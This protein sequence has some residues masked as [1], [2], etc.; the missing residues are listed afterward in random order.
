MNRKI[1]SEARADALLFA[2][3]CILF[4]I[5]GWY[6]L[7]TLDAASLGRVPGIALDRCVLGTG[8]L[9][10]LL[11]KFLC[12]RNVELS[13]TCVVLLGAICGLMF[14][15]RSLG[16][17][18]VD[19]QNIQW[20]LRGDWAEHYASWESYRAGSWTWPLG[21]IPDLFY[22]VGTTIVFTDSTPLLAIPAKLVR[23]L[24]PHPFQYIGIA[25]A[26]NLILQGVFAALLMKRL[27]ASAAGILAG[28]LLFLFAPILIWRIGHD[29]LTAHWLIL[30][31]LLLYFRR[32]VA[33]LPR[34]I[35][36][37]C[38][39]AFLGALIHPYFPP[40]VMAVALAYW[41]RRVWVD[42]ARTP[43]AAAIALCAI[44]LPVMFAWWIAGAFTLHIGDGGGGVPYGIYSFN[45]LGFFDPGGFSQILPRV[46]GVPAEEWEGAAYLG[47]GILALLGL[48]AADAAARPRQIHWPRTHWPLLVAV[49][50]T[51]AFAASTA[52]TLGP[53]HLTHREIYSPIFATYRA[54]GRFIWIAFYVILLLTLWQTVK[55]F[56]RLAAALFAAALGLQMFEDRAVHLHFASLRS[57]VGW[58]PSETLLTD[59]RWDSLMRNRQHV[60][61]L[62]PDACGIMAGSYLP[63]QL[64]A[65]RHAATFNSGYL[66]RWNSVHTQH[67]CDELSEIIASAHYST[68][69]VYVVGPDL[70]E[71]IRQNPNMAC[72]SI[73]GYVVCTASSNSIEPTSR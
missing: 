33:S 17:S 6:L 61:M 46:P 53:W 30:A 50:A 36:P 56:P 20:L 35:W 48:I 34:E 15:A 13:N 32:N 26:A 41:T 18:L 4:L 37:W 59:P 2:A 55:R 58:P 60:T 28:C 19:P 22:P 10:L 31:S 66:A 27:D 70:A 12:R 47:L 40:M 8:F 1:L 43:R 62:P 23:D 24:L 7:A 14:F 3:I 68:D 44:V 63:F 72:Q 11:W 73:D 67:Y 45:L 54:S 52:L 29:S 51:I 9:G 42:R 21:A 25:F 65:A 49:I 64:L 5:D 71:N 16:I 39:V 57:G 69:D 38:L